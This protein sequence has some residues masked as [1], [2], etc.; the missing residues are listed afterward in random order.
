MTKY[1][2]MKQVGDITFLSDNRNE[3]KRKTGC[4]RSLSLIGYQPQISS[5]SQ[6]V[7]RN[8][9]DPFFF[10]ISPPLNFCCWPGR[11]VSSFFPTEFNPL[12]DGV[13]IS[14]LFEGKLYLPLK[15]SPNLQC[16]PLKKLQQT[17]QT[18]YSITWHSVR[19]FC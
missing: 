5:P 12:F 15:L 10:L 17:S 4:M 2:S 13:G 7:G 19:F 18:T 11:D 8:V 3:K 16:Q 9:L 1:M 6:L 14:I